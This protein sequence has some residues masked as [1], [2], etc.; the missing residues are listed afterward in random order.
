MLVTYKFLVVFIVADLPGQRLTRRL[1]HRLRPAQVEAY[2]YYCTDTGFLCTPLL[3]GSV[4]GST[5]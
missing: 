2:V 3:A 4:A 1:T 5:E